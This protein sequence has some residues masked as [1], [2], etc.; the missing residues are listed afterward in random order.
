M[1]GCVIDLLWVILQSSGIF[2]A[3][4]FAAAEF[5]DPKDMEDVLD[6]ASDA[7]EKH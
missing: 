3:G 7:V 5:L 4:A 2:A 1:L 6:A